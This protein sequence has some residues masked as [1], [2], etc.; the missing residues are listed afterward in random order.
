MSGASSRASGELYERLSSYLRTEA[1]PLAFSCPRDPDVDALLCRWVLDDEPVDE[2]LLRAL[3]AMNERPDSR[4]PPAVG[5][6]LLHAANRT[7]AA[8]SVDDAARAYAVACRDEE[9][10][11]YGFSDRSE[12]PRIG[13]AS[14]RSAT[15]FLKRLDEELA[16]ACRGL[17]RFSVVIVEMDSAE[18]RMAAARSALRSY[19]VM[20][21]VG[22]RQLGVLLPGTV[23][24]S[25]VVARLRG[26]LDGQGTVVI[27]TSSWPTEGA[28]AAELID[29]ARDEMDRDRR[30][31]AV[32][33]VSFDSIP[34]AMV[35]V[36]SPQPRPTTAWFEGVSGG[37][38]VQVAHTSQGLRIRLP[39][40]FL[41]LGSSV[42]VAQEDGQ[43]RH[44]ILAEAF[45][46]GGSSSERVPVLQIE[47][48]T[49][50]E[51]DR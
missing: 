40:S 25:T 2:Q 29:H 45:L 19:D 30:R 50:M 28:T 4:P 34:P 26:A 21:S 17:G 10:S 44:G 33:E 11:L 32:G 51:S 48:D 35:E 13:D 27:G 5:R 24:C 36:A 20:C 15:Y 43:T 12:I 18:G 39:L 16:R 41:R 38:A 6:W 46:G 9:L 47:L 31:M 14:D 42:H 7:R 37:L 22:S 3:R 49:A 8:D 23:E 1:E